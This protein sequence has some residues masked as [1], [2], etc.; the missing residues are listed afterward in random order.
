MSRLIWRCYKQPMTVLE[1]AEAL[2]IGRRAVQ[3]T[4]TRLL[5]KGLLKQVGTKTQLT[6]RQV[7]QAKVF[8]RHSYREEVK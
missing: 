6:E 4:T 1:V 7:R 8:A 2:G 5:H 3:D